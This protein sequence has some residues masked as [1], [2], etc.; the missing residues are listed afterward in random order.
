MSDIRLRA[1]ERAWHSDETQ[2]NWE[3][4]LHEARRA[5][6]PIFT[7]ALLVEHV[8]G[9]LIHFEHTAD[10]F[11]ARV[12]NATAPLI[13]KEFRISYEDTDY[14]PLWQYWSGTIRVA[15]TDYFEPS[16]PALFIDVVDYGPQDEWSIYG[17]GG[18]LNHLEEYIYEGDCITD[19]DSFIQALN[20]T[21][22]WNY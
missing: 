21:T 5:D 22:Q 7:P 1:A 3:R 13:E 2:E 17:S 9:N 10:G 19:T 20:A 4:Y 14:F 6:D 15:W 12:E 8:G 16:C 11:I 18:R